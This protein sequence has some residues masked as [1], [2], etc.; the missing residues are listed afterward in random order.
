MIET[1]LIT[2]LAG[3]IVA[4]I[5]FTLGAEKTVWVFVGL[6]VL[7]VLIG[8]FEDIDFGSSN[9]ERQANTDKLMAE[10]QKSK[11]GCIQ[12]DCVNGEGVYKYK[13]GAYYEGFFKD[14]NF[15]GQGLLLYE[16]GV[17][18]KG[19]FFQDSFDG[20]GVR[21]FKNGDSYDG[22]FKNGEFHGQGILKWK[23][24]NSYSGGWK[25]GDQEGRGVITYSDGTNRAAL[26]ENGEDYCAT[27]HMFKVFKC[28][29]P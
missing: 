28:P 21:V 25:N 6:C 7:G 16:T 17:G 4:L 22:S 15:H 1:F 10:Y 24:G 8:I 5:F 14:S 11:T 2:G 20:Y 9:A 27:N 18:Y 19:N 23:S 26:Y 3:G 13:N 12:G 29:N